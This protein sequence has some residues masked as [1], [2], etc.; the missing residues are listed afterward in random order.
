[1]RLRQKPPVACALP[2]LVLA[3]FSFTSPLPAAEPFISEFMPDNAHI[4]VDEDGQFPDWI[5]IQNPNATPFDLAG[6]FLTDN[7]SQ[8][9]KWA[10]P[11]VTLPPHGILVV[12]ASGKNRTS[13]TNRLHTNFQL[14]SDGGFLA[15]VKPDGTNFASAYTNYPAVKEDVS[16][17]IAQQQIA[18]ALIANATPQTLVP[19]NASEL[20]A[21]WNQLAFSPGSN[22]SN[23]IA[24]PSVGFDTNQASGAPANVA[25]SGT[26]VQ[27]TQ[28][29]SFAPNL[30]INNN[31]SDFTHTLG[32]DTAPFWELTLTNQMA[33]FSIVLY[34]RTSCC[35]SRLRD[36][37][38]EI[39]VT[40]ETGRVTNYTSALL[41]PENILGGMSLNGPA[42]I[43]ND[44]V[45]LT[46][47]P[48]SGRIIRV[49]RTP[50]PDLSGSGG[51]GNTDEA[52]VLSLGE[53]VVNASSAPGLQPYFRNDLKPRM[54]NV[55][56]SAFVRIAFTS[57]NVPDTL[58]LKT[59][60]DD[61][62]AAYLNGTE[63]A[64]RNAPGTLAW[65]SS[66]TV[67]RG[68][69][70]AIAQE[71]V[72]VS[73]A[74][75]Q[76]VP[77]TNV[78]A[79]HLLNFGATNSDALFEPE[80]HAVKVLTTSNAFLVDATPGLPNNSDYYFDEVKDTHFSVDRGFFTN[81]F[82]LSIT[83]G[84]P[85]ALIYVSFNA[86]EPGPGKGFLYTNALTITNT[87]VVRARAFKATWKPTQVDT[88]TYLFLGDVI[89]QVPNWQQNNIPPQYFPASW[90]ANTVDY[91]MDPNVVSNYTL[92][93]WYEALTQIPSMSVVTEM[94]NLFDATTGIY[95]NALQQGELWERAA[96]IE[97]LDP[98]NAVP[99][100][101][102]ENC[103]VRI[104][105]GFSRNP[106]FRKHAFRVFFRREYGAGKLNYPLFEN[107]GAQEFDKVDLRTS[108]NYAWAREATAS[109]GTQDTNV[110]EVWCRQTL[111]AMGQP[112]RRSRYYHL[113]L[114]GQYWGIYETDERPEASYG[115]TYF[116]GDRENFDTVKCGNRGT[117][118]D[119]ITEATD[120]NLMAYSNLWVMC[121]THATNATAS[122]YFRILGRN[123]D[124]SRNP[125]LPV[126]V[127]V[128]NL[129]DYMIS[130]FYSGDGDATLSA[131]LANNRPNN[132]FGMRDRTNPNVGFRFFNS[133][134]E[135]T[136]GAPSSQGDRTGPWRDAPG[137]NI[138]NFL[139]ANP[140]YMHED[141][142]WS[143]EYRQLFADHVQKHFFNNGALT[144]GQVTNRWWFKAN[145]LTKAI[146][147][148]SARW[149]DAVREPP[150]GESDWTNVINSVANTWFPPR[151]ALVLAQ[152]RADQL[153]PSN[154][155]PNFSQNG[156]QVPAGYSLALT[157]TNGTG[158]I[159][160][161]LDGTDPR[162]IGGGVAGSALAYSAPL[163]INS[164]TTVR[165]RVLI[166]GV[167]SAVVEFTFFPPQDLSKLLVTEVMYHPPD[168][169]LVDGDEFEF[170]ELK[171]A[172][173]NTLSLTG[174]RFTGI[175]FTFT[176]GTTLAPGQFFLL[177][178]NLAQFATKYPGVTVNGVYS[179]RLD[180]AGEAITLLHPLGTRVLSVTYG[181]L[182]PWPVTPDGFNFSL[183]PVNPNANLDFDNALNWRASTLPGG[184]P[185]ADDPAST[186]SPVLINEVLTHSE[187]TTDFIE[188]YNPTTNTVDIG[189]WFLTDAPGT[190][191]KYRIGD[192][193]L[194]APLS[195]RVF[196]ETNF[197]PTPGLG[198]SFSLNSHGDD[199]YLFSGDL[200][201]NLTGYSH[202][203]S[204]NAAP[205]GETF[206]RYLISTGEEQFPPQTAP[207]PELANAGPRIGPVVINE[208]M[209][210]PPFPLPEFVELK[211][212]SSN[213][214]PLYDPALPTNTWRV[215][216]I[217]FT[218][219]TNITIP[220]NGFVLLTPTTII[221]FT[222]RYSVPAGAQ[223]FGGYTGTLQD[224]GERLELQRPDVP[225]T[226]GFAYINVDDVRYNDKAPWPPAAD[227][228]GPS[229]Q[230]QNAGLYGND[231][232]SWTAAAPTPGGDFAGGD[233]PVITAQPQS[234]SVLQGSNATFSVSVSGTAPFSYVWRFYGTNLPNQ[235]SATLTVSNVQPSQA[236]PYSVSI[237]NSAG[238]ALSLDATLAVLS[239]VFFTLQPVNTNVPPG[240]N[241]TLAASAV[242]NGT[243]RYQWRFEGTNI[244]NATNALHMFT[245][246]NIF[247]HHGNF[248]V[249]A[250]DDLST[251]T[252]TNAFVYVLAR[253]GILTNPIPTTVLQG[254]TARFSIL[255]TGAPPLYYRWLRAGVLWESNL[256]PTLTITNC[257][258]TNSANFRCIVGNLAATASSLP[259]T[260]VPLLVLADFDRDGMADIWETNYFGAA[261][262]NN[263]NNANDDPDQ[264]GMNNRQEYVANTNPTNAASVLKLATTITNN[265][266]LTFL[267]QSSVWYSVQYQTNLALTNWSLLT[268][269]TA[270]TSQTRTTFVATPYPPPEAERY[271]RVVTPPTQ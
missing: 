155:A 242:G 129:I 183:V 154:S 243:V 254:G 125:A 4:L 64:Q 63:I 194:I 53:V 61:G 75:S 174:L 94:G 184:S 229:L 22:W 230:K 85:D 221:D 168:V 166:N 164:P 141:L 225:D 38:I 74:A 270:H 98:T 111:G 213:A 126:M 147:A 163:I 5:E 118:P 114:N 263:A 51:Q 138:G 209:Y 202:G 189:G 91:G 123:P 44:L 269:I 3:L 29:G 244:A 240:S 68:F 59:R 180:N 87:T 37:T 210:N 101:F 9:N 195:Y 215:N 1:M 223:I 110:R 56:A 134:C 241:V 33:I 151:A 84:T 47:G 79:V 203:F 216:G 224:S 162:A 246:A 171:N 105:G 257:H 60:Y 52:A 86:D 268:N 212:I 235:T 109:N 135:H 46:G 30:A 76:I 264:D 156:G 211:N 83:S 81:A 247:E 10:F 36:I 32:T 119:F 159:Y 127:D 55:N 112:Y 266:V 192:G 19:T 153:Y 188:L 198:T 115:A 17:G 93:Q 6:Y 104:R 8:L 41:N 167:W 206:G 251:A 65:D 25:P 181:V 231:P 207:T 191:M 69:T 157:Q 249:I 146:R 228:S 117:E 222:N 234:Q 28:N 100:R 82:S 12:F 204:F 95:A 260:G 185:G 236:G 50:D 232:A 66:A 18:T 116:G 142:M 122:N 78:L 248:S 140:Q 26:A 139:Y 227:G 72:D 173:T 132:W 133:D 106:Q 57:A 103:G 239:P 149:G 261:S 193:T 15:L 2:L 250:A 265:A 148:N 43:T 80:L 77:G 165:A 253:P 190:P 245:N 178:R 20:P 48:V 58:T 160:Y 136:L 131:F 45:A 27:S 145:Q 170:I 21:D 214:V 31:F 199:V 262:T 42:A 54:L 92:A 34:N 186:I 71:T 120:G 124:G 226:N 220:P 7:P 218:F 233:V 144:L 97:L 258:P 137:S 177:V 256:F 39:M 259:G 252:S 128:D 200:N 62:F 107:E 143:P 182:A 24:P 23:G 13:D 152:L 49:R 73:T 176:N 237:F 208:V 158:V 108:S 196:S 219:P 102:Q 89:Y 197:N 16:F 161:T 99:G 217:G 187:V 35:G 172:G 205:D 238:A 70:N 121:R 150:Y 201:T 96:S 255:A 14:D 179:G 11:S 113:Y 271:Y 67:D 90:G 130:I 169:E 88:H 267:S 40:N 175:N